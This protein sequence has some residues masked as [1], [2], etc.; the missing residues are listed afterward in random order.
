MLGVRIRSMKEA[1]VQSALS[2]ARVWGIQHTLVSGEENR[3][4]PWRCICSSLLDTLLHTTVLQQCNVPSLIAFV[5]HLNVFRQ[6][7]LVLFSNVLSDFHSL[8]FPVLRQKPP[9]GFR[10]EPALSKEQLVLLLDLSRGKAIPL[11]L[12][13]VSAGVAVKWVWVESRVWLGVR[14]NVWLK[15]CIGVSLRAGL[16]PSALLPLHVYLTLTK[17]PTLTSILTQTL[18]SSLNIQHCI[19]NKVFISNFGEDQDWK[20][21]LNSFF[22]NN[23]SLHTFSII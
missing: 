17:S 23:V 2:S 12:M 19:S 18:T 14:F 16:R 8:G 10:D 15:G 9:W 1:V 13:G 11:R 5:S 7:H 20:M 22:W 21:L 6:R 4:A 3:S